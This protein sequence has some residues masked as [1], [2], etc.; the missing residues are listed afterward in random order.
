MRIWRPIILALSLLVVAPAAAQAGVVSVA[1]TTLSFAAGDDEANNLTVS[2]SP[3]LYT[4]VDTGATLTAG[5]NCTQAGPDVTC[6]S[7]GVTL[8]SLD[9]RDRAD[10]I[11]LGSGTVAATIIGGAGDDVLTGGSA[12]DTL[13]GGADA[14]TL[15]GGA[16]NDTLNGDTGDDVLVGGTGA[17][18]FNGGT[19]TDLADY[20]ARTSGVTV[21]VETTANDGEPGELDNVKVDVENVTG[22]SGNDVLLGGTPINVLAGGDGD[23]SLDG[24]AANDVLDGGAGADIL[25][26]GAA[27]DTVT[28][29]GRSAAVVV[30]I[31]GAAN[32]GTPGELDTVK[33]DVETVIGGS[34]N[35]D[36]SGSILAETLFGGAGADTL[37]GEGGIDVLWGD[38]G[39]DLLEGGAAADTM[40]GD[41]GDDTLEGGA[42]GDTHN[43]G[44]GFDSADYSARTASVTAS[45]D[46]SANDGETVEVDNVKPDVERL[47]GGGGDD[48]LTGNN[49]I[50]TLEGGAGDDLMDPG[51]G[52]GDQLLG[53]PGTDTVTYSARTAPVTLDLDGLADDG[54]LNENDRIDIDVE[55]L[56]GGAGNDRLAGSAAGNV[57]SG[58]TGNDILDGGLGGDLFVGGSGTDTADYSS[59]SAAV[60]ADPDGWADDGE[61]G[62]YDLVE[63]DVEGLAGGSGNDVLT[64]ALGT[65]M[66][67][68][69]PGHDTLDGAQGDDDIDGGDGND[70]LRGGTGVDIVRGGAGT[71]IVWLRDGQSDVVR[72]GAG[73]DT[74]TL[75][76]I[77][78]PG[79]ECE[80]TDVPNVV[81]PTG[82]TGA[83]GPA[84][85][86]GT[87]GKT[88]ATGA[89][90]AKGAPGRNAIVTCTPAKGKGKAAK[91]VVTCSVKLAAA[92]HASVR[93]VFK[94]GNHVVAAARGTRHSGGKVSLRMRRGQMARG[95]YN[96]VL[97]FTADGRR[98]TVTQ[99][100]RVR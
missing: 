17:D 44:A 59:R 67:S 7:A 51:K 9:G 38:A 57:L 74:A 32:D 78:D 35:D 79:T 60:I 22:G 63:T 64:G 71:D 5:A 43:G 85:P 86:A 36:L 88:G 20:S 97:T 94:R 23:D 6:P 66:L 41:D 80:S 26:G 42:G 33:A 39:N 8:L 73:A 69:G 11:T 10:T 72:C 30:T 18:S 14:D 19:G 46:G 65:N 53:G 68:G 91:V 83:A 99:R 76:A 54:E 75:D 96:L 62:E 29:A 89:T 84:G 34:G 47:L 98:S 1:G 52:A 95:R 21:S 77:D 25:A 45:L 37:R 15:T 56:T 49:G 12:I 27:V 2:F 92:A 58:G 40:N 90:G 28:Y 93:A 48:T 100:V 24:E 87:P 61:A 82:P 50:N 31:D 55:N 16:L 13:N 3:G 4:L 81:G 70:D